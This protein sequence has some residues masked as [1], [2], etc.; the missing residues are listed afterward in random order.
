MIAGEDC[1]RNQSRRPE[2]GTP[3]ERL[4]RVAA[5][6]VFFAKTDENVSDERKKRQP[7]QVA[8]MQCQSMQ[9]HGAAQN[10]RGGD[11][12]DDKQPS[13]YYFP[14]KFPKRLFDR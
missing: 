1:G 12:E 3:P 5:K 10:H 14:E 6:S 2:T 13:E 11:E 7:C 8:A 9:H 4:Q